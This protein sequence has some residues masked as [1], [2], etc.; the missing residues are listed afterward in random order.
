MPQEIIF[1]T[2]HLFYSNTSILGTPFQTLC[3][4]KYVEINIYD[5]PCSWMVHTCVQMGGTPPQEAS[6]QCTTLYLPALGWAHD[7]Y[8][9][10]PP[11]P[12][13]SLDSSLQYQR[14]TLLVNMVGQAPAREDKAVCCLRSLLTR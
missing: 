10:S 7:T 12:D 6:L 9:T 8:L 4:Q 14:L 11:V 2:F 13:P 5:L 1:I 3:R